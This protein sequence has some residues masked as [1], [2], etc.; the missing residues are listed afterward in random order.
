MFVSVGALCRSRARSL[1]EGRGNKIRD[2]YTRSIELERAHA[3]GAALRLKGGFLTRA[4]WP[5]GDKKAGLAALL[6]TDKIA[7]VPQNF[8][9][10]GDLY[11][12]QGQRTKAF[13]TWERALSARSH[14]T[15]RFV[16]P[17]VRELVRQRLR[18]AR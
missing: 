2:A 6:E 7:S 8:L 4:P 3:G 11:Y 5:F 16:D 9:L 1:V 14:E 15:T 12:G 10:L 13:Q 18:F 17:L